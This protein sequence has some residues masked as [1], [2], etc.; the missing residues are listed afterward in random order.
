MVYTSWIGRDSKAVMIILFTMD[1]GSVPVD[2]AYHAWAVFWFHPYSIFLTDPRSNS[3]LAN[4][5]WIRDQSSPQFPYWYYRRYTQSYTDPRSIAGR[6]LFTW[7]MDQGSVIA[8]VP[9]LMVYTVVHW[10]QIQRLVNSSALISLLKLSLDLGSVLV[11][12][13]STIVNS[14]SQPEV[15]PLI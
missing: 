1:Q 3:S 10:S 13:G 5:Y 14:S 11:A 8:T 4:Y 2:S 7:T 9:N 12:R 15:V 6:L